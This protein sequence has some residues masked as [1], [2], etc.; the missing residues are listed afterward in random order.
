M[1]RKQSKRINGKINS[2][3]YRKDNFEH[4]YKINAFKCHENNYLH[5]FWEIHRATQGFKKTKEN[6]KNM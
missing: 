1:P 3:L 5:F 6:K 4:N 2:N